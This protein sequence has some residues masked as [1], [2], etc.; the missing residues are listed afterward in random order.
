MGLEQC[1]Q[2]NVVDLIGTNNKGRIKDKV[3][4]VS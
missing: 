4:H 1:E 3:L 2:L